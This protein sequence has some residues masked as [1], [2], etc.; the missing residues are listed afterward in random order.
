MYRIYAT[1][2]GHFEISTSDGIF[3][4]KQ[5]I[6]NKSL[7][8]KFNFFDKTHE[9]AYHLKVIIFLLIT[10]AINPKII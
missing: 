9:G 1:P 4:V 2:P 5:L 6:Y 7:E 8:E 3:V 10:L